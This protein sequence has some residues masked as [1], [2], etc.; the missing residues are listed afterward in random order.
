MLDTQL[1]VVTI[2]FLRWQMF[3]DS[4]Y[5]HAEEH[6]VVSVVPMVPAVPVGYS[7]SLVTIAAP[8][9]HDCN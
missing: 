3:G 9:A 7:A 8:P 4:C 6:A 5:P 1:P 2:K